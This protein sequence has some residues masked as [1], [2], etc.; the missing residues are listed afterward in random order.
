MT[1]ADILNI[2]DR[3]PMNAEV[4][5]VAGASPSFSAQE[6]FEHEVR[7]AFTVTGVHGLTVLLT[8]GRTPTSDEYADLESV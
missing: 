3:V 6:E 1:K 2:L 5:F 4:V 7:Q 8:D